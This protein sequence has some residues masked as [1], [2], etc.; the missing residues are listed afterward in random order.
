MSTTLGR[1]I[2]VAAAG[3][4]IHGGQPV[5]A[6]CSDI[7]RQQLIEA[8]QFVKNDPTEQ[9][10]TAGLKNHMW[11]AFLNETGKVCEVV[12]TAGEGQNSGQTWAL[13]RVIAMQKANTSVSLS[14]DNQANG[15]GI[16]A[17]ASGALFLAASPVFDPVTGL[18]AA[19]VGGLQ[20][21][22]FGVQFSNPVDAKSA[23]AGNPED[24]GTE[25][26]PAKSKR[27]GGVN[28]FGGG[29]PIYN[30]GLTTK[31]GAI[32]VSGDTSCTDHA[33]AWRVRERLATVLGLANGAAI[34]GAS[35]ISE[36][37][38]ITGNAYPGCNP[39]INPPFNGTAGATANGIQ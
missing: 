25:N 8:A 21:T 17:W 38:N 6:K 5:L 35:G 2:L 4:L 37:L 20:G 32:G 31:L 34:A 12:N 19:S 26:D 1:A 15:G 7:P 3:L 33:F 22:L 28:V 11:V 16:Q 30:A 14:L 39:A 24:Y 29:L 23:Y 13:S 9:T 27:L 18:V 10:L 36:V